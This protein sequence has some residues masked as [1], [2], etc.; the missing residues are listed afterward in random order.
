MNNK[1][2]N[3]RILINNEE[4][5][6]FENQDRFNYDQLNNKGFKL[7]SNQLKSGDEVNIKTSNSNFSSSP[8]SNASPQPRSVRKSNLGVLLEESFAKSD[9]DHENSISER[10]ENDKK[11][12]NLNSSLKIKRKNKSNL[13]YKNNFSNADS[14]ININNNVINYHI[15]KMEKNNRLNNEGSQATYNNNRIITKKTKKNKDNHKDVQA[16]P[17]NS[18]FPIDLRNQYISNNTNVSY[19]H[20]YIINSN[21]VNHNIHNI[22]S[23][24]NND[25]NY[26]NHTNNNFPASNQNTYGNFIN[27]PD[28]MNQSN[29]YYQTINCNQVPQV[30][31]FIPLINNNNGVINQQMLYSQN[32]EY[33]DFN[34]NNLSNNMNVNNTTRYYSN[35]Y[36]NNNNFH[37]QQL[38]ARSSIHHNNNKTRTVCYSNNK[39]TIY[40]FNNMNDPNSNLI[41]RNHNFA[42]SNKLNYASLNNNF[43]SNY[44][45][46]QNISL[47]SNNNNYNYQIINNSIPINPTYNTTITNSELINHP[48]NRPMNVNNLSNLSN[49]ISNNYRTNSTITDNMIP[50][51]NVNNIAN[52]NGLE[53]QFV[54]YS[55]ASSS[56]VLIT[57]NN[58]IK[59]NSNNNMNDKIVG[60]VN[61]SIYNNEEL[62]IYL[63]KMSHEQYGCRF[64]QKKI[65]TEP[66]FANETLFKAIIP[67]ITTVITNQFGNYLIQKVIEI[68]SLENLNIL[69]DI[70]SK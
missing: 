20:N 36:L 22:N 42:S 25:I 63:V 51:Y 12:H 7:S 43:N 31:Q 32:N 13:T 53:K 45:S 27:N 62:L 54:N 35:P 66:D 38:E 33:F 44:R 50:H 34:N 28:F 57:E 17:I 40:N 55:K 68:L 4:S 10:V 24:N 18:D 67:E 39:P 52:T 30:S 48:L 69:F 3:I 14:N 1:H 5:H 46:P 65:I 26:I 61:Y 59:S 49:N 60:G 9:L 70:V 6:Y 8:V 47:P 29:N 21:L 58:D 37:T 11:L 2:D 19:P 15:N 64:L 23:I 16:H 56:N 41:L